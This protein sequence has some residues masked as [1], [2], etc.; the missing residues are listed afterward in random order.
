MESDKSSFDVSDIL[1]SLGKGRNKEDKG[2]D[3]CGT[4]DEPKKTS[5]D[6]VK[7]PKK[8]EPFLGL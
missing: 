5:G 3:K 7:N 6:V 8:R 1:E 4:A 2:S